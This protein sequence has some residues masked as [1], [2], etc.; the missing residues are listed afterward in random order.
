MHRE[1][2]WSVLGRQ[3]APDKLVAVTKPFHYDIK[4][5]VRVDGVLTGDFDIPRGVRQG[6]LMAPALLN[7]FYAEVLTVWRRSARSDVKLGW[8]VGEA[9]GRHSWLPQG[10]SDISDTVYADDTALLNT[11]AQA[12]SISWSAYKQTVDSY[13]L[14]IATHKTKLMITRGGN[15]GDNGGDDQMTDEALPT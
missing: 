5:N 15:L 3:G 14:V 11:S 7:L 2:L 8:S 13:G 6:C 12:C 9:L 1:C 4:G 10:S